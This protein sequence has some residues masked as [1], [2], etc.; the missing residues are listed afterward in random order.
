[1]LGAEPV[2]YRKHRSVFLGDPQLHR[3]AGKL[4]RNARRL[5]PGRGVLR[6]CDAGSS[7]ECL[8]C[9]VCSC[10]SAAGSRRG[11][12]HVAFIVL[13]VRSM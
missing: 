11:Q 8:E 12:V 6:R 1:M 3:P 7:L 4:E 9:L 2:A 10:E 5:G 13:V